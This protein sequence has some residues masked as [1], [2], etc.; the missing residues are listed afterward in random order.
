MSEMAH[1]RFPLPGLFVLAVKPRRLL[2][3][4][5]IDASAILFDE[6]IPPTE[7]RRRILSLWHPEMRLLLTPRGHLLIF[8]H[9]IT[10][11][12]ERAPGLPLARLERSSLWSYYTAA[13]LTPKE[14]K[15]LPSI[16]PAMALPIG[17]ELHAVSLD[18]QV[19]TVDPADWIDISD[20]RLLE[21]TTLAPPSAPTPAF[22]MR[23]NQRARAILKGVPAKASAA[24]E[25]EAT[26]RAAGRLRGGPGGWLI[27]L[28]ARAAGLAVARRPKTSAWRRGDARETTE[29]PLPPSAPS[30]E[31]R[32]MLRSIVMRAI[33]LTGLTRFLAGA[34]AR[35]LHDLFRMLDLGDIDATLRHAVG[36]GAAG[37]AMRRL[38]AAFLP[39]ARRSTPKLDTRPNA[40]ITAISMADEIVEELKGRYRKLHELLDARGRVE[41]A[42]FVLAD[43]LA[44]VE[45]AVSYLERKG[46]LTLAAELAEGRGLALPLMIRQWLVAGDPERAVTIARVRQAFGD[47]VPQIERTDPRRARQLRVLWAETLAESGKQVEAIEVIWPVK[48]KRHQALAWLEQVIDF[49]GPA[50]A[51]AL[52]RKLA[53]DF[54]EDAYRRALALLD[55]E[56]EQDAASRAALMSELARPD[57]SMETRGLALRACRTLL[58]D[59]ARG[60]DLVPSDVR[61]ALLAR[62]CSRA[63]E[64]DMPK[65][66]PVPRAKLASDGSPRELFLNDS[67]AGTVP[68]HDAAL[69]P[70]GRIVAAL[71]E[72]G[73][74]ILTRDGRTIVHLA[75][76]AHHLV[77]SDDGTKA[78]A[79]A[80][81]G[82]G[83]RLARVDL[84]RRTAS[85]WHDTRFDTH[86]HTYDGSSWLIGV[87]NEMLEIDALAPGFR[88]LWRWPG[89]EGLPISISRNS[90]QIW[91]LLE[92]PS[93]DIESTP[94]ER[95]MLSLPDRLLRERTQVRLSE[96][97]TM[98]LR[99]GLVATGSILAV[100]LLWNDP[101]AETG[102]AADVARDTDR[103]RDSVDLALTIDGVITDWY[104]EHIDPN[105][106]DT[107]QLASNEDWAAIMF[108]GLVTL[109][110][111]KTRRSAMAIELEHSGPIS[112]QLGPD[113][114]TI[115]DRRGRIFAFDLSFGEKILEHRML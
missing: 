52:G 38:P 13:P 3:R 17:G 72:A 58:Q 79:I 44:S 11:R 71:G 50:G 9:P 95:R 51:R 77:I 27:G 28:I 78:I 83:K 23:P 99:R 88:T 64:T 55:G 46:K 108:E 39:R 90:T 41:D 35:Y 113:T 48:E 63:M 33:S 24:A 2:F 25:F 114:L 42:A 47:I 68:V 34:H 57:A 74:R 82:E 86:A 98:I 75:E 76:P 105:R 80:E 43:L 67:P 18:A 103:S 5:V 101:A 8:R 91:M 19:E 109:V 1:T 94:L 66:A 6:Q 21:V 53:L 65:F 26:A 106:A 31:S 115:A 60:I 69:L 70:N 92:L 59:A 84:M 20:L 49:G 96:P 37:D 93:T 32:G 12:T 73:I 100:E 4:G 16:G 54:E 40:R 45:E 97:G 104:W 14:M 102:Q 85:H 56:E 15:Q 107:V 87:G 61:A 36:I 22:E 110:S 111:L 7:A 62:A 89:L 29:R 30:R 81:R 112:I 10:L